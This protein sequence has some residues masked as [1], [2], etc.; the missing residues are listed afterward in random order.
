MIFSLIDLIY[1]KK[2]ATRIIFLQKRYMNDMFILILDS[3]VYIKRRRPEKIPWKLSAAGLCLVELEAAAVCYL[4]MK[5]LSF[6]PVCF[7]SGDFTVPQFR[8]L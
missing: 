1:Q 4:E 3:T 7:L 8:Y 5:F 2:T 6:L